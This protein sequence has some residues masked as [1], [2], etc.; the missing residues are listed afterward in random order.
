MN[1][2]VRH[3]KCDLAE[4][5]Q[6]GWRRAARARANIFDQAHAAGGAIARP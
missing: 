5:N 3:E 1:A 2:V 6:F 4:F